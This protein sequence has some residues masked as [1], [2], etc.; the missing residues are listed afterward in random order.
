MLLHLD[1]LLIKAKTPVYLINHVFQFATN[2]WLQTTQTNGDHFMNTRHQYYISSKSSDSHRVRLS[3]TS[4][5][6]I[7]ADSVSEQP[8]RMVCCSRSTTD[9]FG[10]DEE[11]S[12]KR[13]EPDDVD[14][15]IDSGR[16][17]CE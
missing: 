3:S 11:D 17:A 15:S 14:Y 9:V 5:P 1:D 4:A 10:T 7:S 12:L 6:N 8:L 2:R 13:S 16:E